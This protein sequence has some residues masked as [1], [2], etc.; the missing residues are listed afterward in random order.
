MFELLGQL[1]VSTSLN[2]SLV[3][4][5][6]CAVLAVIFLHIRD[7]YHNSANVTPYYVFN[8]LMYVSLAVLGIFAYR[9]FVFGALG[10]R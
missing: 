3:I 10:V 8:A 7:Q 6:V 5:V 9:F 2:A 1:L 4:M